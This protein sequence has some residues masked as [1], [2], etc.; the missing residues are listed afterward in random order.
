[1][2]GPKN[3]HEELIFASEEF[4]AEI[5]YEILRVMS[6]EGLS[7]KDLAKKMSVSA[8]RVS[9][10]LDDEANLTTDNITKVFHSMGY[11]PTFCALKEGIGSL[12]ESGAFPKSWFAEQHREDNATRGK[13]EDDFLAL[14]K[15]IASLSHPFRDGKVEEISNDNKNKK[16]KLEQTY[17]A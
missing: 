2:F 14:E 8:A 4:K 15:L 10:I 12:E 1:M 7:Q 9:Q 3:E 6:A 13:S 16:V 11:T 5:Q 17:V